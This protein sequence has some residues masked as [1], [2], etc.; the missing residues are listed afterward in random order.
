MGKPH[1]TYANKREGTDPSKAI[2][3]EFQNIW[4]A[5]LQPN[6]AVFLDSVHFPLML[7]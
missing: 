3:Q 2:T 4:G 6:R 1:L 7:C 5:H